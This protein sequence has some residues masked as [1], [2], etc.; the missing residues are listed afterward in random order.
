MLINQAKSDPGVHQHHNHHHHHQNQ[1]RYNMNDN[2]QVG[3]VYYG[4][5]PNE[6]SSF[7]QQQSSKSLGVGDT[8]SSFD[9]SSAALSDDEEY[10]EHDL[11]DSEASSSDSS[12]NSEDE[13]DLDEDDDDSCDDEKKNRKSRSGSK[14]ASGGKRSVKKAGDSLSSMM[15]SNSGAGGS[16]TRFDASMFKSSGEG[17]S[18]GHLGD[19]Y[20]L[21][22]GGGVGCDD[23]ATL[24]ARQHLIEQNFI[25]IT[26]TD[27][28][29][30]KTH[31]G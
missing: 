26:Q 6:Y 11:N 13:V 12:N 25:T 5:T 16:S 22:S 3:G 27:E 21:S 23:E 8:G 29:S 17:M 30:S 19:G 14:R 2:Q 31:E 28:T 18:I 15:I 9:T 20:D 1:F 10:V 24:R 7:Q 4:S